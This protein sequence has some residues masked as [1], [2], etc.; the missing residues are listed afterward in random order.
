MNLAIARCANLSAQGTHDAGG[1][2]GI[3]SKG[4]AYGEYLAAHGEFGGVSQRQADKILRRRVETQHGKV[5][6]RGNPDHFR[7]MLAAVRQC[8][9]EFVRAGYDMKVGD[10]QALLVPDETCA[11]TARYLVDVE[12]EQAASEG[13]IGHENHRRA[14]LAEDLRAVGFVF[15]GKTQVIRRSRHR[16]SGEQ[17]QREQ[18]GNEAPCV[19]AR[20]PAQALSAA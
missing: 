13:G 11:A 10:D 17:C 8:H 3:E 7:R 6:F 9:S 1:Q 5:F 2:R 18:A 20:H 15:R 4:I 14:C 16:L 19:H 12:T